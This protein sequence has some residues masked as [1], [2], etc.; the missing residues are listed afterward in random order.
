M[1]PEIERGY[2]P[3]LG[4][5]EVNESPTQAYRRFAIDFFDMTE[6]KARE[7]PDLMAIVETKVKPQ[8]MGLKRDALVQKWW[9]Y[10][11]KRP[12]LRRAVHGLPRVL[13]TACS[14]TPH[15]SF[16]FLAPNLIFANTLAVLPLESYGAFSVLQ[17]RVHEAWARLLGSSMKDDLRYT[18]SA[19]L[20]TFPFPESYESS[21]P[22]EESGREYYES[23]ASVMLLNNDGLTKIYNRFHDPNETSSAIMELRK[24]H[25][26]MDRAV[27]D[28]Y[29]WADIE[30]VCEFILDY[31]DE[32]DEDSRRRRPW[33]YRWPDET[34]DKVLAR[35]LALNA[36]RADQERLSGATA[37]GQTKNKKQSRSAKRVAVTQASFQAVKIEE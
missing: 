35:L 3:D 28:A 16:V 13:V 18:P 20:E 25:A 29:G 26:D 6:A 9:Q 8:R 15:L 11:E 27:L 33:R 10:G 4:S 19:C 12:G 34:R 31:E 1:I 32:E 36:Q 17:S 7:W 5:E 14:G 21:P 23:R 24:L 30:T 2:S 37:D 22:L